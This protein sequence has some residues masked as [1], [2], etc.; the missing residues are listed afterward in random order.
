MGLSWDVVF[1]FLPCNTYYVMISSLD[2]FS[3]GICRQSTCNYIF[4][5]TNGSMGAYPNSSFA[6]SEYGGV[7][8][9]PWS[10]VSSE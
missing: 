5:D 6:I 4:S 10:T 8:K 1:S 3:Y 9:L 7:K 2:A